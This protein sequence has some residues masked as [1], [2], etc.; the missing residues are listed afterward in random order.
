MQKPG[1]LDIAWLGV[2]LMDMTPDL[3][4]RLSY[5]YAGGVYVS[6]LA[7]NSPAEAAE[8]TRG[9]IITAVSGRPIRDTASL[10]DVLAG[11]SPGQVVAITVW[12]G[13]KTETLKLKAGV[14]RTKGI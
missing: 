8:I 11:L 5:P 6:T 10:K 9:D 1:N 4:A 7:L 3:A 12:R 2:G 13:G 14:D